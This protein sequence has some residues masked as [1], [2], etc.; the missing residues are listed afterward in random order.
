MPTAEQL[1]AIK[2]GYKST[3]DFICG[4]IGTRARWQVRMLRGAPMSD[5]ELVGKGVVVDAAFRPFL[6]KELHPPR[7]RAARG[8]AGVYAIQELRLEAQGL[9]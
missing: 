7:L 9:A 3:L 1:D 4:A 2:V 8:P 6:A 5:E